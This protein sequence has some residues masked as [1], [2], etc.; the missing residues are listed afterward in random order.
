M[1]VPVAFGNSWA[2]DQIH[3]IASTQVTTVTVPDPLTCSTGRELPTVFVLKKNAVYKMLKGFSGC[4]KRHESGVF[5]GSR[6]GDRTLPSSHPKVEI[7]VK[8]SLRKKGEF[9]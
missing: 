6:R 3:G 2:K 9:F 5:P 4:S 7:Q 8:F 1:A